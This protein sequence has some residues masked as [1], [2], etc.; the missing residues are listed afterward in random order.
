MRQ[1]KKATQPAQA[2]TGGGA[3]RTGCGSAALKTSTTVSPRM[4]C[5]CFIFN[6]FGS[7]FDF[8]MLEKRQCFHILAETDG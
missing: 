5:Q 2:S 7:P 3:G 8:E 4:V 6:A 1:R